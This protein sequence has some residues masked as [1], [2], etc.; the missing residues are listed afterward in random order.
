MA[1]PFEQA[2]VGLYI[3]TTVI[4]CI[5]CLIVLPQAACW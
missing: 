5:F 1:G 4:G 2:H 3:S